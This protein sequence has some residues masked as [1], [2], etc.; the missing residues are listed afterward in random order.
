MLLTHTIMRH[1]PNGHVI[2]CSDAKLPLQ[3]SQYYSYAV[4][5]DLLEYWTHISSKH[6]P[7]T[8]R[9]NTLRFGHI[10]PNVNDVDK[11]LQPTRKE[12]SI[13][14]NIAETIVTLDNTPSLNQQVLYFGKT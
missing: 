9:I 3:F 10:L 2:Q 5:K 8:F 6:F 1:N 7:S 13:L 12:L 14:K 11:N 4:S